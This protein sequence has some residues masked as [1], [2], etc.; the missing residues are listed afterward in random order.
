M[1]SKKSG[2]GKR[3]PTLPREV[4]RLITRK[5]RH[6]QREQEKLLISANQTTYSK[7]HDEVVANIRARALGAAFISVPLAAYHDVVANAMVLTK[8][9]PGIVWAII[10][11]TL[12]KTK[13]LVGDGSV[14]HKIVD[15]FSWAAGQ[16]PFT[17]SNIDPERFKK[18]VQRAARGHGVIQPGILAE[19][20]RQLTHAAG[21][22]QCGIINTANY[23]RENVGIAIDDYLLAQRDRA[24]P[25]ASNRYAPNNARREAG[26]LRTQAMYAKWQKAFREL[27]KQRRNMS[28]VWYAQQIAKLDI[29]VGRNAETIRKHMKK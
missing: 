7:M 20:D 22:A 18:M 3:S 14:L 28:D 11:S 19:F 4:L 26:K 6:G 9:W 15:E 13:V 25:V 21:A 17:L 12:E 16:R 8:E 29:A 24:L 5:L 27:K 1:A 23:A 2:D 10:A